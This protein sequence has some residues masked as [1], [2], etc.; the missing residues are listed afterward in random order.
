MKLLILLTLVLATASNFACASL[1][2]DDRA[3]RAAENL[4]LENVRV[5]EK[6]PSFG[7][8]RGCHEDDGALY[9]LVGTDGFG[10]QRT[11]H[12]C[13]PFTLIGG[14]TVRN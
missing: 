7:I 3:I 12:V 13:A 8:W 6:K 5:V 2:N 1:A 10:K 14:Y 11:I 4:G 9:K